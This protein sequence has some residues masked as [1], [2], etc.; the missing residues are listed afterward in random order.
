MIQRSCGSAVASFIFL[1]LIPDS[2]R[3]WVARTAT[4]NVRNSKNLLDI[5]SSDYHIQLEN[6][7][8]YNIE[9]HR[10][11]TLSFACLLLFMVGAPL[12]AIIRKG[13][14]GM[15]MVVAIAFFIV[16]HI[17][18][19]S[20]EKLAKTMALEP[21]MG[22]WLATACLLPIAFVLVNAARK[23]AQVF[24][25]ELYIRVWNRLVKRKNKTA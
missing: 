18:T 9:W 12:G 23:D 3:S 16:F 2:L 8:K 19:I 21:W 15:P 5:T 25:K 6:A 10:K 4:S 1:L 13:G 22:M 17:I 7:V 14:L 24:N 20:G 11:F